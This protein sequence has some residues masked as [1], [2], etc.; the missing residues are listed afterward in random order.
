MTVKCTFF[1]G[2]ILFSKFIMNLL[3]NAGIGR[4]YRKIKGFLIGCIFNQKYLRIG[5]SLYKFKYYYEYNAIL[6]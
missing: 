2:T 4:V 3:K 6:L 5:I 1:K